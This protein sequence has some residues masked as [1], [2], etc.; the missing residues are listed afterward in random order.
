M[1]RLIQRLG[2]AVMLWVEKA[3]NAVFGAELNPLYQ[4]GAIAYFL[5]WV[6]VASGFY[7]YAFYR[8][9]VSEA[10]ASV[11]SLT[12][13][14]WYLGGIMRSLHR[15]ASDGMVLTML[16]HMWRNF[17]MNR[18]SGFRAFS[19]FT[20]V[21]WSW[22]RGAVAGVLISISLLAIRVCVNLSPRGGC[23]DPGEGSFMATFERPKSTEGVPLDLL[24]VIRSSGILSEKQM[25][26]IR[27]KMLQGDYP[28]DSVDLAERLVREQIL[29]TY[30]AK[31]FLN[32]RSNGLIV[33][34]YIILDRIGSGSMGRV[35]KAH[36]VMM[37]RVVALKIIAPEI[38]SN[39]RVVARFQREMKLVGRLDH[40]NVVRAFDESEVKPVA[41][42]AVKPEAPVAAVQQPIEVDAKPTPHTT[43]GMSLQ[44]STGGDTKVDVRLVERAGEVHIAVRTPDEMLAHNMREDL[45]SLTGKLS[46]SGFA[47]ESWAPAQSSS[48][49]FQHQD[50]AG[51]QALASGAHSRDHASP[52]AQ[53][54]ARG[55]RHPN[56]AASSRAG[57]ASVRQMGLAQGRSKTQPTARLP[58]V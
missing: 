39:E 14:Q 10:Y 58:G 3:F 17:T 29:T 24:P 12:H 55:A 4:L 32:N 23:G 30:Q 20:D 11:E 38:A 48:S 21:V 25:S 16:V 46:Q 22:L 34:R 43:Q 7:I 56:G 40:P 1:I 45:G 51:T 5:F 15:Y 37:D 27:A 33:G 53:R 50:A 36:H 8:T 6:I 2:Q 19:W 54:P 47:T 44:I 52:A 57:A 13:G 41:A 28:L 35:Y 26:E 9:G 18:L 49:A 42:D 31:R